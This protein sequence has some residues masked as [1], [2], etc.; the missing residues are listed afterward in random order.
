MALSWRWREKSCAIGRTPQ[1]LYGQWQLYGSSEDIEDARWALS[2][3][4]LALSLG[5]FFQTC[6]DIVWQKLV[7][8]LCRRQDEDARWAL[9]ST[10]MA[11]SLGLYTFLRHV[12]TFKKTPPRLRPPPPPRPPPPQQQQRQQ[13]QTTSRWALSSTF[14]ALSLGML[15]QTSGDMWW[16]LFNQCL[17]SWEQMRKNAKREEKM[18]PWDSTRGGG[19]QECIAN[20]KRHFLIDISTYCTKIWIR[21]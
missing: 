5:C 9:S 13:Q 17:S 7:H 12:V 1:V 2:S 21:W 16:H 19:Q 14:M 3:T 20:G 8:A 18:N 15:F 10:F 4:F 11:L 6:G